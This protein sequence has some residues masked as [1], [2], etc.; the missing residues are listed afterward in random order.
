MFHA[1]LYFICSVCELFSCER[2]Q[3]SINKVVFSCPYKLVVRGGAST[4][5]TSHA[6]ACGS[7]YG[8]DK[9]S[10]MEYT[11]MFDVWIGFE[12]CVNTTKT[13]AYVE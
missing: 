7:T 6:C 2:R 13:Y 5:G 11:Y 9:H 12:K 1:T 4:T 8:M 3:R 10:S